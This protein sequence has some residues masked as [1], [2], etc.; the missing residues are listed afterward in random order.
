MALV[1][2]GC[3]I[4]GRY[5]LDAFPV[6]EDGVGLVVGEDSPFVN[7]QFFHRGEKS[8]D[9]TTFVFAVKFKTNLIGSR[10]CILFADNKIAFTSTFIVIIDLFVSSAEFSI[11]HIF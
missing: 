11:Y 7:I 3:R 1:L 10:R 6:L 4:P 2:K 9:F 8:V 5:N